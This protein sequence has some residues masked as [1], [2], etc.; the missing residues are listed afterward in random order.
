MFDAAKN[1]KLL[2]DIMKQASDMCRGDVA[3]LCGQT[4]VGHGRLIQCLMTNK[5]N[6][7]SNC[8]DA[9][10]KIANFISK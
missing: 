9:V 10:Q 5:T 2:T 6:V 4:Q 7:S 3:K 1:V 8:A